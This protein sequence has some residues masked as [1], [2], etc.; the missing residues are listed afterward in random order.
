MRMFF[1]LVCIVFM[2]ATAQAQTYHPYSLYN[3]DH[4]TEVET[5]GERQISMTAGV[6]LVTGATGVFGA[7]YIALLSIPNQRIERAIIHRCSHNGNYSWAPH[8]VNDKNALKLDMY[9]GTPG[10]HAFGTAPRAWLKLVV[11]LNPIE[12]TWN[13]IEA[14]D[15]TH[16]Y[17]FR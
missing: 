13:E 4:A 2:S 16:K 14:G 11:W 3:C 9:V 12:R 10:L 1:A 15:R 17:D 5:P 6:P 7:D 8:F